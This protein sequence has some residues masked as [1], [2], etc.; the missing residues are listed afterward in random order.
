[1]CFNVF[2]AVVLV[3]CQQHDLFTQTASDLSTRISDELSTNPNFSSFLFSAI[4]LSLSLSFCL[5]C[6][7]PCWFHLFRLAYTHTHKHK[8]KLTLI[9]QT[10]FC[11]SSLNWLIQFY[12]FIFLFCFV[13]SHW[14]STQRIRMIKAF[15]CSLLTN[16]TLFNTITTTTTISQ[17]YIDHC[18]PTICLAI[19][20]FCY[21]YFTRKMFI[22]AK[23]IGFFWSEFA[24]QN[25]AHNKTQHCNKIWNKQQPV[26]LSEKRKKENSFSLNST[27]FW[28][29][30]KSSAN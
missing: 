5:P 30:F 21:C 2:S 12:S 14:F 18:Y 19:F 4:F 26:K 25:T 27:L 17:P 6:L 7:K 8:H 23:N 9:Y 24:Q 20:I 29:S 1:M 3:I 16:R 13:F 11:Y 10:Y 15:F 28:T 22:H